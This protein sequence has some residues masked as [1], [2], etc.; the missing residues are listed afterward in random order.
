MVHTMQHSL[1]NKALQSIVVSLR[2]VSRTSDDIQS[3]IH[4]NI[5]EDL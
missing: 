4:P 5:K 1:Y 2:Q 3:G